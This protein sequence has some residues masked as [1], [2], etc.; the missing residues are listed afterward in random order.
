MAIQTIASRASD[1]FFPFVISIGTV[2][3]G[4]AP[5]ILAQEVAL[6]GTV[7]ST[8][9]NERSLAKVRGVTTPY[10][11]FVFSLLSLF[12]EIFR[13]LLELVDYTRLKPHVFICQMSMYIASV[14]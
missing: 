4:S 13:N 8:R 12:S 14:E 2:N 7:R 3:G 1:P 5:N 11:F 9:E 10:S 6:T